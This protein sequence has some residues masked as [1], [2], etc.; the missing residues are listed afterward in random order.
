M[1]YA[2]NSNGD[3]IG[4]IV[5]SPIRPADPLQKIATVFSNEIK[6]ALHTYQSIAERDSLIEERREWGMLAYVIDSGSPGP[7]G[8][9]DKTYQ[10]VYDHVSTN[11]M[12][13]G[14]WVQFSGSGGGGE[15]LDS[16]ISV[17]YNQPSMPNDVDR[18]L[19]GTKPD[20]VIGP[21]GSDWSAHSPGFVAQ[22]NMA[23][24][25][26]IYTEPVDGTSVRVDDQDNSI[27]RYEGVYPTGSWQKEKESQVRYLTASCVGGASYSSITTPS[28][29]SYDTE[30]IY[31]VKF[32]V[33]NIGTSASL[34]INGLDIK[35]LKKTDGYSLSDIVTGDISTNY[36]YF[37]TYDGTG[38]QLLNTTDS[39]GISN[40]YFIPSTETVTV[41]GNVQYWIYGD[42]TID[43]ILTNL[44]HVVVVNGDMILSSTPSEFNNYGTYSNLYFAEID[45]LG[46]VNYVPRWKTSYMLT[47]SSSIYDD[48]DLVTIDTDQISFS[49]STISINNTVVLSNGTSSGYLMAK[50]VATQSFD[51]NATYTI[52]H[53]LNSES[54]IFNLWDEN[55]DSI[56]YPT[57]SNKTLNSIDVMTTVTVSNARI[58]IIS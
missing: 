58:V 37:V 45:G 28:I 8:N 17:L 54:I 26:W 32:D 7:N 19:V 15:W 53:N 25:Y 55:T 46:Q 27:Y 9:Y 21:V 38:F 57:T 20:D 30:T 42:L 49:G 47:A 35:Y 13:P 16:V 39:G 6:G 22:Y 24:L 33:S 51:Q 3:Y 4:T 23:G 41:P 11:I 29:G 40:K 36:S 10:L 43:G 14:N 2:T 5:A 48:G 12:D 31:I 18:Y 56:I 44:G 34:S 1:A 52:S 50:Y